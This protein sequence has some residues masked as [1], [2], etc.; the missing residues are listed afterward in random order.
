MKLLSEKRFQHID[1]YSKEKPNCPVCGKPYASVFRN[2]MKN[3]IE[4]KHEKKTRS[5]RPGPRYIMSATY[6]EKK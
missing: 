3:L 6:C 4:Y 5:E 1:K 2:E